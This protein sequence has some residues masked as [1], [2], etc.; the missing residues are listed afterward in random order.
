MDI[1]QNI[2]SQ[3]PAIDLSNFTMNQNLPGKGTTPP[4]K[5]SSEVSTDTPLNASTVNLSQE[6]RAASLIVDFNATADNLSKINALRN[7]ESFP[8]AHASIS[9]ETVKNLLD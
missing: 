6:G 7:S 5:T 1:N 4:A 8:R 2:K 9:Y 3:K